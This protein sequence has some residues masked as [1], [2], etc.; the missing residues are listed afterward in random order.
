MTPRVAACHSCPRR[1]WSKCGQDRESGPETQQLRPLTRAFD[2][3]PRQCLSSGHRSHLSRDIV[4][5]LRRGVSDGHAAAGGHRGVGRGTQQERGGAPVRGFPA[6]GDHRGAA[7]PGGGRGCTATAVPASGPQP[8][9][10][11]PGARGGDRRAAQGTRPRR[12]RD[13]RG[14]DRLP[15]RPAARQ[16]SGDLDDLADPVRPRVR[17]RAAAQAPEE[18][19]PTVPGRPTQR[20]LAAGHHALEARRG[21]RGGDPQPA[22]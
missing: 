22:R 14:H 10:H 12:A 7:L 11:R 6:L 18:Q 4:H 3:C 13:R 5:T 15:P 1:L 20:A 21:H 19:L 16:G 9:A 2:R 17:R 8:A